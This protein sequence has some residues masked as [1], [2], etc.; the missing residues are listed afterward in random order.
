MS[1]NLFLVAAE[2]TECHQNI[3]EE[4]TGVKS[5]DIK[6]L[7]EPNQSK[8]HPALKVIIVV[9]TMEQAQQIRQHCVNQVQRSNFRIGELLPKKSPRYEIKYKINIVRA[10]GNVFLSVHDAEKRKAEKGSTAI[11]T[12]QTILDTLD[13]TK[14]DDKKTAD[15]I[16]SDIQKIHPDKEYT[17]AKSTGNSYRI[18]YYDSEKTNRVQ[19]SVGN[20]MI[21]VSDDAQT[22]ILDA[23][24][25]KKRTDKKELVF[26]LY[27][28]FYGVI[29]V[30]SK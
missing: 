24:Q 13:E 28:P 10:I 29:S 20:I 30:Y 15:I 4:V 17:W 9:E 7:K 26:S 2:R 22:K 6:I 27:L 14:E 5:L 21:I 1:N 12:L 8:L 18:T 16:R 11:E 25:R 3:F 19:A 23:P